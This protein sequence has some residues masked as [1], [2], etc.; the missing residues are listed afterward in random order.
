MKK[1]NILRMFMT[2]LIVTLLAAILSCSVNE[3]PD[4]PKTDSPISGNVGENA[5]D[6]APGT[7][8][9]TAEDIKSPVPGDVKFGGE[10]V[11]FYNYNLEIADDGVIDPS[12]ATIISKDGRMPEEIAGDVVYESIYNRNME[13]QEKLVEVLGHSPKEVFVGAIIGIIVG[14]IF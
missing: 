7:E 3:E 10:T 6:D 1:K 12:R 5:A 13:V 11:R 14:I 8:E 2:I 4:A 9:L